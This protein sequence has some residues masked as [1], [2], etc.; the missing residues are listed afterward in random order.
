M[1]IRRWDYAATVSGHWLRQARRVLVL[2]VLAMP[3]GAQNEIDFV[4]GLSLGNTTLEFE[5][6]LDANTAFPSYAVFA[7]AAKGNAFATLTWSDSVGSENISEEDELGDANRND[8]D[9]TLG[10][11]LNDNWA[12]FVGYKDGE[13]DIEF[14][15]RDSDIVQNEF[16]REQGFYVGGSYSWRFQRAGSL[17]LTAAYIRFDSDLKFTEGAEEEEDEE[18]EPTEFDDLEGTFS[19]DADGYSV[20]VTWVMPLTERLAFRTLYKINHYELD[21]ESD[22]LLFEP[23]QELRYFQIGVLYAF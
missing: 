14:R 3:A 22:G 2:L 8:L 6:K 13:T 16:Y 5:E 4:V 19:G 15:V 18:D 23:D 1:V 21:V 12:A 17:S 20:G 10:Y 9:V 11:R 7:S